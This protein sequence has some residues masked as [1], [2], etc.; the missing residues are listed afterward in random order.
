[1]SAD[2]PL[3]RTVEVALT[4]GLLLSASLLGC[5]LLLGREPWLRTGV[6]LLMLTP[7]A[8]VVIVTVGLLL[9]R[10][11]LFTAVSLWILAV[12]AYSAWS[13]FGG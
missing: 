1:M 8:R 2:T 3:D 12:L 9:Q 10:D 7:V 11:W 4:A 6:I 13:V 5:G